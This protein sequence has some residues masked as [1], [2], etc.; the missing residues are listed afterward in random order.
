MGVSIDHTVWFLFGNGTDG[1]SFAEGLPNEIAGDFVDVPVWW[2]TYCDGRVVR[3]WSGMYGLIDIC[4]LD[5]PKSF[6]EAIHRVEDLH[7]ESIS[8]VESFE[9]SELE[10]D[11]PYGGLGPDCKEEISVVLNEMKYVPRYADEESSDEVSDVWSFLY[12][13]MRQSLLR[14]LVEDKMGGH[15]WPGDHEEMT[16]ELTWQDMTE[17]RKPEDKTDLH[18]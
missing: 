11:G 15:G 6:E 1:Q 12:H 18:S 8:Y 9:P 13:E 5:L 10:G 2:K 16:K 4:K 14:F 7:D 17:G 3:I